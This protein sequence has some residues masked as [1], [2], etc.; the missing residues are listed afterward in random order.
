[1]SHVDCTFTIYDQENVEYKAPFSNIVKGRL[2]QDELTRMTVE[3][4]NYWV[5]KQPE[6]CEK[7]ELQLL[8][9]YLYQI[10]F[11]DEKIKEAFAITYKE[12]DDNYKEEKERLGLNQT[13]DMRLR[14]RLVFT[15]KARELAKWP[16]E[17]L[18]IPDPNIE[19][20]F[21]FTGE[22]TQ[23]ILTRFVPEKG[24]VRNLTPEQQPLRI[25]VVLS[26]PDELSSLNKKELE[27]VIAKIEGLKASGRVMVTRL[28]SPTFNELQ[29][30]IADEETGLPHILHFIGHGEEGRI[31]LVKAPTDL[32]YDLKKKGH[33][34]RWI[35][36]ED[37]K[38]LFIGHK[39]R[40]I[41]LHA[42]EGAA[43]ALESFK[44]T[45]REL[46]Y[47]DIPAVVAM[48]Y[49]ISNSD[50]GLFARKFYEQIGEGKE[51]DEAVKV[52]R[53]ALGS[54]FP[55]WQHRRFGT[56]VVYL[57]SQKAIII[58]KAAEVKAEEAG[59]S[60]VNCPY[61]DKCGRKVYPDQAVCSCLAAL[62]LTKLAPAANASPE[63]VQDTSPVA[64]DSSSSSNLKR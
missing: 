61:F 63:G 19:R 44:N 48:Q 30:A 2:R 5:E 13:P 54:S 3:R 22:R 20:G 14:V 45:A 28:H 62:P 59:S 26:E 40:L 7:P 56:P 52:G 9:L 41:F 24:R 21:F 47:A 31:A 35:N 32:D 1:M 50:A 49:E 17:F 60:Q 15:E 36:S 10:L 25:L 23:L 64:I 38:A 4:L 11:D 46:V 53:L 55:P 58:P 39:P 12:F 42:C 43:S 37:M 6:F 34:L 51:I 8:G 27:E 16:W 29:A 18:Y 57:Q 33:Q